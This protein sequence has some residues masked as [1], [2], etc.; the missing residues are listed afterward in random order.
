MADAKESPLIEATFAFIKPDAVAAG[1]SEAALKR[2]VEEGFEIIGQKQITLA[3]ETAQEFYA[4]HKERS[5]YGELVDF[6]T[7]GPVVALVLQKK[8]AIPAW[9]TLIGPTNSNKARETAPDSL[10]AL[11]GIDGSKNAFHG[12]DSVASANREIGLIFPEFSR[13][14]AFIKPDAV[15]AGKAEE[16]LARIV[17]EGF[18]I[19]EKKEVT[20]SKETAQAFYEEHKE[21]SFYGELV[22]FM[23]SGPV[24]ALVL[25]RPNAIK[26]WRNLMGPTNSHKARESSPN[27]LRALFGKDGSEN[28]T[29]G[30]DSA[31]SA[32]REIKLIFNL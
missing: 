27:S 29:H 8:D 18:K 3:K 2:I 31:A 22:D 9:R 23:T 16:I 32:Q 11:Y 5:F 25:E 7:S 15:A 30:S 20:L 14:F 6:M 13:T 12:S 10:R 28:A 21:R 4:E 24:V 17:Q 26:N 19:A 1:H